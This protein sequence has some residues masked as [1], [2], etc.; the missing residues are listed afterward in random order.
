MVLF[1]ESTS[2][3]TRANSFFSSST[4]AR[5][6]FT[7]ASYCSDR[8]IACDSSVVF[9]ASIFLSLLYECL[10]S[11]SSL[12]R[13][14]SSC[15]NGFESASQLDNGLVRRDS[16]RSCRSRNSLRSCLFSRSSVL[17]SVSRRS[18]L[19]H[20]EAFSAWSFSSYDFEEGNC[21]FLILRNLGRECAMRDSYLGSK[22]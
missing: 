7:S 14:S 17:F 1:A 21:G 12:L 9:S 18:R 11:T 13:S 22:F 15:C 5:M 10:S 16:A 2:S 3:C 20:S 6:R 19:F 8:R 4:R